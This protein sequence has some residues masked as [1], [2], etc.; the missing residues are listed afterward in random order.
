MVVNNSLQL[1]RLLQDMAILRLDTIITL[2]E[3]YLDD[4]VNFIYLF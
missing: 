4:R 1:V 3:I 2:L